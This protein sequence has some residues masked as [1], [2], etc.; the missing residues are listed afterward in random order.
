MNPALLLLTKMETIKETE[1]EIST[2][3]ANRN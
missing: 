2:K 1:G 3:K